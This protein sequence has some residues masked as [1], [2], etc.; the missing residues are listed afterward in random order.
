MVKPV[1]KEKFLALMIFNKQE[2]IKSILLKLKNELKEAEEGISGHKRRNQ[3]LYKWI[4]NF[5]VW[6]YEK[7]KLN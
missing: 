2:W 5:E 7:N 6:L 1:L 4:N 3:W